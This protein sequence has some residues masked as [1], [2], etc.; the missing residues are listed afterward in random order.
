MRK[1]FIAAAL[2]VA[3][4]GHAGPAAAQSMSAV[5]QN[6]AYRIVTVS[7][8]GL[9]RAFTVAGGANNNLFVLDNTDLPVSFS[10][11]NQAVCVVTLTSI[12]DGASKLMDCRQTTQPGTTPVT[13]T[14]TITDNNTAQCKVVI[15]LTE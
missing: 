3:A 4:F 1:S 11:N 7:A 2:A 14:T 9:N 13:C 8:P 5:I 15:A 6:Q 10:W 12:V